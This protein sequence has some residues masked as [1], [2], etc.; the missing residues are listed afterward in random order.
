MAVIDFHSHILPAIDDGSKNLETSMRMLQIC[1]EHGVEIMVATPHFY[2]D[3]ERVEDF[4]EKRAGAYEQLRKQC[5]AEMPT[6]PEI[7]LGAEVAFFEGI[8]RAEKTD[9]LT[10]GDTNMILLEMPF[11]TW[12]SSVLHEVK[13]L[14]EDR[15]FRL[16][17]AHL[18]RFLRI[19][20]NRQ[21]VE[22]LMELPVYV[23]I[24]A[25]SLLD[26]KQRGA[27][28]KMFRKNE[29]HFL[30]SDCHGINHRPPNLWEGRETLK[31]KLGDAYIEKMDKLGSDLL[32]RRI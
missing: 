18:E 5:A 13:I 24:N 2:A 16:M 23:Q 12:N 3:R 11:M 8:S 27:L 29:A 20:G 19:A 26:W 30:G 22:K 17:I 1:M 9:C 25:E 6:S 32:V 21:W 14:L 7:I 4:L 28:I 31:K 15:G 10:V